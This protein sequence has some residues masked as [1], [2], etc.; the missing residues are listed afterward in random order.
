MRRLLIVDDDEGIRKVFR[1]RL[2]DSYEIID[3][4]DPEKAFLMAL[5]NRPDVILMDLSMPGLSGFELCRMLSTL[6]ITQQ[7]P[8]FVVSGQDTRNKAFCQSLGASRYFEKPIDFARLKSALALALPANGSKQRTEEV[9]Y[10]AIL[11]LK[12]RS[13]AGDYFEV[14]ATTQSVSPGGFLCGCHASVPKGT[15]VDVFLCNGGELYL[16]RAR[17]SKAEEA[18]CGDSCV[19]VQ[20]IDAKGEGQEKMQ[21]EVL[22]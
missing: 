6:P 11:K 15:V 12:G 3:T 1:T 21:Q 20:F 4:G 18:G 9:A 7:I 5:L 14:R 10:K 8:I 16:G 19:T 2:Q 13:E 22:S 17:A